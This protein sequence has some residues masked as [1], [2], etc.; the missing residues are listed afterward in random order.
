MRIGNLRRGA[1]LI[2]KG[3]VIRLDYTKEQMAR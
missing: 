3:L 2:N 1:L